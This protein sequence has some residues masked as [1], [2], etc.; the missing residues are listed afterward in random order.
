[1]PERF[2]TLFYGVGLQST[3]DLK[4]SARPVNHSAATHF[5]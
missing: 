2:C 4:D 3:L 5:G 1:M